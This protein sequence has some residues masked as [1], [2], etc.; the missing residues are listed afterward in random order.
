MKKKLIIYIIV[1]A[2]ISVASIVFYFINFKNGFSGVNSDWGN[3]GGYIA[4][5]VGICFSLLGVILIYITFF[6]QR[7]QQ[8]EN[9]FQQYISNYYSLLNLI[10]ERWLHRASE[11]VFNYKGERIVEFDKDRKDRGNPIYQT[12][13]EIFGNAIGYIATSNEKDTFIEIF[14][15][16]NNVFQHYCSYLI[17]LFNIIDNNDEL[18]VDER[19]TYIK[20][21]LSILSTYELAFFAFYIKYLYSGVKPERIIEPLKEKLADLNIKDKTPHKEQIEFIIKELN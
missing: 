4:G 2:I 20:R 16:H 18:T 8:F 14:S 17:E 10:K 11:K 5:T 1:V 9:A 13:R 19:K 3:F 12:G 6:Q 15:I 7:K 21:F